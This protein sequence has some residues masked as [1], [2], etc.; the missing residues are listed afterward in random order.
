[1]SAEQVAS[2]LAAVHR[3][4]ISVDIA[5]GLEIDAD[6]LAFERIVANLVLNAVRHGSP[7]I[8]ISA[9]A[10]DSL[11]HLVVE[12]RGGGV[13][14]DF[15][16]RM[17]DQFTRSVDSVDV[18]GSGLGLALARSYARGGGVDLSR[19][20]ELF[21]ARYADFVRTA[22]AVSGSAELGRDAVHDAF[23]GLV[24]GRRRYRGSGTLEAWAWRAVVNAA[25]KQ[26][27]AS[28]REEPT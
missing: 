7:P 12:D 10:E 22:T 14:A 13:P 21:R 18:P 17:F 25:R 26:R 20:E 23:V 24:R 6:E 15:R 4:A 28:K 2:E 8:T 5:R 19:R 16:S 1:K 3:A 9:S 27:R 11:L